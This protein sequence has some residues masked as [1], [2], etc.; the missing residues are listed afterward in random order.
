M[1]V[2]RQSLGPRAKGLDIRSAHSAVASRCDEWQ[3]TSLTEVNDVLSRGVQDQG[4]L[5]GGQQLVFACPK[6]GVD[7]VDPH[8]QA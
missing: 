8:D 1:L 6:N 4:G 5:A 2:T 3:V 7:G